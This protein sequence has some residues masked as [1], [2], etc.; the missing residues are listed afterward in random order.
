M[1]TEHE[2]RREAT[3]WRDLLTRIAQDLEHAADAE[4]E[5]KRKAW[6][7][8]RA[9]RIRQ[10]LHDGVPDGYG[11]RTPGARMT[12]GDHLSG[13]GEKSADEWK[14]AMESD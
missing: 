1:P 5:R 12:P 9:M 4:S 14:H 13:R 3:Y 7:E 11:P 10:R 2:V 8:S 6:F